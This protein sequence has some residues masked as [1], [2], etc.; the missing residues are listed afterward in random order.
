[1]VV[2]A[3]LVLG[4]GLLDALARDFAAG[5]ALVDPKLAAATCRRCH[6]GGLCRVDAAGARDD[7]PEEA[8]DES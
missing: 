6:L 1:V 7:V 5:R 3:G 2:L 8:G 4:G